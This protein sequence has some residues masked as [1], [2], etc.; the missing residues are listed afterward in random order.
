M[1][2]EEGRVN[3]S[4]DMGTEKD[5]GEGKLEEVEKKPKTR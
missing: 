4:R 2:G 3:D 5:D 1:E